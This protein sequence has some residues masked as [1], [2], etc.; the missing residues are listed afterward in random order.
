MN[1]V[2]VSMVIIWKS[3]YPHRDPLNWTRSDKRERLGGGVSTDRQ[4]RITIGQLSENGF[5]FCLLF[6]MYLKPLFGIFVSDAYVPIEDT[7]RPMLAQLFA[8][9]CRIFIFY[10]DHTSSDHIYF[11]KSDFNFRKSAFRKL[12]ELITVIV[13]FSKSPN[14]SW[15]IF[16]CTSKPAILI[17]NYRYFSFFR[18]VNRHRIQLIAKKKFL[19]YVAQSVVNK[20]TLPAPLLIATFEPYFRETHDRNFEHETTASVR[21]FGLN[22]L[23]TAV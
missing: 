7:A 18:Q 17:I 23:E 1:P 22:G 6:I 3:D 19:S 21:E 16:V 15:S 11:F 10:I 8:R 20:Y 14:A 5:P 4:R 12:N 13:I 9:P 2:S